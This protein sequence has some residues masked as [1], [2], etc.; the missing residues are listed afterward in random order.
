MSFK[1]DK[2]MKDIVRREENHQVHEVSDK[3]LEDNSAREYRHRYAELWQNRII[4]GKKD[5]KKNADN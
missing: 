1:F 3:D 4:W 2:F 5:E